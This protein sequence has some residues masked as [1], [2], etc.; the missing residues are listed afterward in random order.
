MLDLVHDIQKVFRVVLD[1]M[2]RPGSIGCLA[3]MSEKADAGLPMPQAFEVLMHLLLDTEV[4]FSVC[5]QHSEALKMGIHQHTYARGGAL[6]DADYIFITRDSGPDILPEVLR[7]AKKGTLPDPHIS[8]TIIAEVEQI[9]QGEGLVL[10]GPG[11][12]QELHLTI[13]GSEKWVHARAQANCEYP[14]G[15][16]LILV[17]SDNRVICLP[18]TTQ[19]LEVTK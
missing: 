3:L 17:D 18:R 7:R 4:S 12:F 16:D 10:R 11:I 5:S 1:C 14:L 2:A 6:E 15:I 8:A 19:I 13:E 9:R